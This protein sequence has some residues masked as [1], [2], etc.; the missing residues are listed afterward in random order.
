MKQHTGYTAEELADRPVEHIIEILTDA[1]IRAGV[2]CGRSKANQIKHHGLGLTYLE[3]QGLRDWL[4]S[5]AS[6]MVWVLTDK[7]TPARANSRGAANLE[8]AEVCG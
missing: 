6:G 7:K 3:E 8:R 4:R 1:E 5:D 2:G